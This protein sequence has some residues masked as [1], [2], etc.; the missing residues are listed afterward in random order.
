MRLED[1][2]VS[3]ACVR[4]RARVSR[5][6]EGGGP[7]GLPDG[8]MREKRAGETSIRREKPPLGEQDGDVHLIVGRDLA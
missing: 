1:N 2:R 7:D 3:R 4:E 5:A 8:G 6:D